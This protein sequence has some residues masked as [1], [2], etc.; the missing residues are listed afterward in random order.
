VGNP[1]MI[2]ATAVSAASILESSRSA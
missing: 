2:A 1:S